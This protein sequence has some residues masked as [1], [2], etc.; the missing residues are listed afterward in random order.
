MEWQLLDYA[1]QAEDAAFGLH[2]FL[3]DVPRHHKDIVGDIAGLYATSKALRTLYEE[4]DVSR[5]GRFSGRIADHMK[6]ALP[7]LDHTFKQIHRVVKSRDTKSP[8]NNEDIWEEACAVF[9]LQGISLSARLELYQT[10]LQILCK[11]LT[12]APTD[13]EISRIRQRLIELFRNQEHPAPQLGYGLEEDSFISP[14]KSS[15]DLSRHPWYT[16]QQ[17][18]PTSPD[19]YGLQPGRLNNASPNHEVGL[20]HWAMNIFDGQHSSTPFN[21]YG[22]PSRCL[23]RDEPKAIQF[24]ETDE[25]EKVMELPLENTGVWIRLYWRPSDSRARI[26]FLTHDSAGSRTRYS[27]P[28]SALQILRTESCLQLCRINHKD[29]QLDLWANLRF[30]I[31]E[32]MVLFFYTLVAMK[33]QDQAPSEP[34]LVDYLHPGETEEFGGKVRDGTYLHALRIFKDRDSGGVRLQSALRRGPHKDI[35]V[36]TAFITEHIGKKSWVKR[37]EATTVEFLHL[38][39]YLFCKNYSLPKGS[40]GRFQ[41]NFTT[42]DDARCFVEVCAMLSMGYPQTVHYDTE[43]SDQSGFQP[44]SSSRKRPRP[45]SQPTVVYGSQ[46]LIARNPPQTL[47]PFEYTDQIPYVARGIISSASS[48]SSQAAF[49]DNSSMSGLTD[50]T[51]IS[52]LFSDYEGSGGAKAGTLVAVPEEEEDEIRW[53]RPPPKPEILI[54]IST[55]RKKKPSSNKYSFGEE[56]NARTKQASQ[57]QLPLLGSGSSR[58]NVF[59]GVPARANQTIK[60]ERAKNKKTSKHRSSSGGGLSSKEESLTPKAPAAGKIPQAENIAPS[61][62]SLSAG[63]SALSIDETENTDIHILPEETVPN[64]TNW[65]DIQEQLPEPW[66]WDLE[67]SSPSLT[68]EDSGCWT[69]TPM[70]GDGPKEFPLTIAKAPVVIPVEYRWPPVAAVAPPPD[71]QPSPIDCADA[72]PIQTIRDIFTTFKG[73]IGMYFLRNALL[74]LIVPKEFDTEWASSHLPHK[75][76]GLKICYIY[77]TMEPTMNPSKTDTTLNKEKSP[78]PWAFFQRGSQKASVSSSQTTKLNDHIEARTK[79]TLR[80]GRFSGRIGLRT[81]CKDGNPYLLMS[82]HVITEALISR[83]RR[84][85]FSLKPDADEILE[86]DWNNHVEIWAGNA[87]AGTIGK[88]FDPDADIYPTG[89]R[90]DL[91]LVKLAP[92]AFKEVKS[93]IANMGWLSREAWLNLRRAT[94]PI[95]IL[96][97]PEQEGKTL[98]SSRPSDI[99]IVGEGIFLNKTSTTN[100]YGNDPTLW[101]DLISRSVLYRVNKDFENPNGYSGIA[102]YTEGLRTDRTTGPG[103]IGFQSFV[104]RSGH[105]QNFNMEGQALDKRIQAGRV[106][107]YGA[108]MCPEEIKEHTIACEAAESLP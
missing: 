26:L 103:I 58:P 56:P 101:N 33:R 77:G 62:E 67:Y 55:S 65:E 1:K 46:P 102:L 29:G 63:V 13:G 82:S 66:K 99:L 93:P 36:W 32:R 60:I 79:S 54:E 48:V 70:D 11:V 86:G 21:G 96:G 90:Y 44:I 25:F 3:A 89:F 84:S 15:F 106:A 107:F 2:Q 73:C 39:P 105:V 23:G 69:C 38:H 97:N 12:G 94:N 75:Y 41:L 49:S 50:A 40:S 74:Q 51:E 80:Q 59:D 100:D 83:A 5:Y 24:L 76:G 53:T 95:K 37:T 88:T 19:S 34:E 9:G 85:V 35:V 42:S 17:P 87:K 91:T 28:L 92:T 47:R 45:L 10:Y 78:V 20:P 14:E 61:S 57:K 52:T 81:T 6:I 68:K 104:Q 8:Y 4:L 18:P 64:E 22:Q 7:S 108:F 72:L 31:Y 98:K 30:T 16:M 27:I 71:P 43:L